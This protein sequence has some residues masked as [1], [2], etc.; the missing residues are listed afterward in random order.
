MMGFSFGPAA[1]AA[2]MVGGIGLPMDRPV[3]LDFS[4]HVGV[5]P[6]MAIGVVA[7]GLA[8]LGMR[9]LWRR[10][11]EISRASVLVGA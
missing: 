2:S 11:H 4:R 7:I 6:A 3:F 8:A 10:S 5:A 1:A 9:I